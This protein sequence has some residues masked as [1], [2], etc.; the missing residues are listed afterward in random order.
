MVNRGALI[1]LEGCDCSGKSS[2]CKNIVESLNS[3]GIPAEVVTFPGMFLVYLSSIIT[4]SSY[5]L[6]I[7]FF[8]DRTTEIGKLIDAFLKNNA[9]V[10][11]Q[12]IHLLFSANRWELMLII[13]SFI[14]L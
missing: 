14:L 5:L 2:Q 4:Q 3:Q 9:D 11:D 12:T 6:L 1:V 13:T 10:T 7:Y 8:T